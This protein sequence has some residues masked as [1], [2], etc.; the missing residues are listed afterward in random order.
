MSLDPRVVAPEDPAARAPVSAAEQVRAVG[1]A[2]VTTDPDGVVQ[3]W[4]PA[5]ERLYGW[6][7]QEAVGRSISELCVPDMAL[8]VAGEIMVALRAGQPWSGSFPVRRKDGTLF[9]ALVTDAGV[10]RDGELVGIVG[11]STNLGAAV[12]PLLE[13]SADAALMLRA[14]GLVTYASPAVTRLFGWPVEDV[15]GRGFTELLHPDD[16]AA[17]GA[18]LHDLP[19]TTGPQP[20]HELRVRRGTGWA[21]TEAAFSSFLDDPMVRGLVCNLRRSLARGAAGGSEDT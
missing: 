11:T 21:E 8:E 20:V 14:D 16:R 7:E 5:A 4:N 12:E 1:H 9:T 18:W 3:A 10:Y 2:V 6:S 19:R 17:V 15:V 13:R